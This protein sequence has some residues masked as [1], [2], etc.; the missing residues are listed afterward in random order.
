VLGV[1]WRFYETENKTSLAVKPIYVAP[2]ASDEEAE[3]LGTG[4]AS[5]QISL[6]LTQE[7]PWGAVHANLL[8]GRNVYR[9]QVA[10]E[11]EKVRHFS[12]APVWDVAE[13]WKLA[14]DL[15]GE[16]VISTSQTTRVRFA[17]LG[18]IYS[19]NPNLDLALGLIS[20]KDRDSDVITRSATAGAT[21]RFK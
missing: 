19:P 1:K 5:H 4:K 3:G 18:A 13:E 10:N 15:G 2:L 6:I 12:V 8:G 21:W 9:D 14:V 17:E 20:A 11:D 7:M 16:R